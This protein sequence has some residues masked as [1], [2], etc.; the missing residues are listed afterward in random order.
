MK[1]SGATRRFLQ[2]LPLGS[3]WLAG[4]ASYAADAVSARKNGDRINARYFGRVAREYL[5][6][7]RKA[8]AQA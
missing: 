6:R 4:H 3:Y 7:W 8:M 5:E 1:Q 2:E